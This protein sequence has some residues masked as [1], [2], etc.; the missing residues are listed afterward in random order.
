MHNY[1]PCTGLQM[2]YFAGKWFVENDFGKA[3]L[4]D[5]YSNGGSDDPVNRK[6]SVK[7]LVLTFEHESGLFRLKDEDYDAS[8]VFWK[9][10][11]Y[12][13]KGKCRIVVTYTAQWQIAS[14]IMFILTIIHISPH[15]N[16]CMNIYIH[17]CTIY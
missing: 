3:R 1:Y 16:L 5:G 4:T 7:G 15:I 9:T 11:F 17:E 10:I 6:I 2:H 14:D 8:L 12:G 13:L